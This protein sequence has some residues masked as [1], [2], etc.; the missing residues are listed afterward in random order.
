MSLCLSVFCFWMQWMKAWIHLVGLKRGQRVRP[1]KWKKKVGRGGEQAEKKI[2]WESGE[3]KKHQ[4]VTAS[5]TARDKFV[6][7]LR[8]LYSTWSPQS[9]GVS[10]AL[11]Y[12][13]TVPRHNVTGQRPMLLLPDRAHWWRWS[14]G[15][16]KKMEHNVSYTLTLFVCTHRMCTLS[17]VIVMP[18]F[19]YF[20]FFTTFWNLLGGVPGSV[21]PMHTCPHLM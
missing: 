3:K 18:R 16:L 10:P 14:G 12:H 11:S 19:Y 5:A 21:L 8:H 4:P 17:A 9:C 13:Q 6:A 15:V 20:Y 7:V 1:L 2:K